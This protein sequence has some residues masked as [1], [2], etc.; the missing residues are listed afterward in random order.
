MKKQGYP[1]IL[2]LSGVILLTGIQAF[3][4][5]WQRSAESG[6]IYCNAPESCSVPRGRS[7]TVTFYTD[8]GKRAELQYGCSITRNPSTPYK[9]DVSSTM[10]C[11]YIN[12][13]SGSEY[14]LNGKNSSES[15]FQSSE[16][17]AICAH[18]YFDLGVTAEKK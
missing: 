6:V 14:A 3:A 8:G 15:L 16:P 7:Y 2:S 18:A 9:Q 10:R 11:N 4:F 17:S 12:K 1:L 13:I 5:D